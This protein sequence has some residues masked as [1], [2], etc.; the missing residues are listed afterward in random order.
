MWFFSPNFMETPLQVFP[1]RFS[2]DKKIKQMQ[3][4]HSALTV[5]HHEAPKTQTVCFNSFP[6]LGYETKDGLKSPQRYLGIIQRVLRTTEEASAAS[7]RSCLANELECNCFAT[8]RLFPLSQQ[9]LELNPKV[10][11]GCV[12]KMHCKR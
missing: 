8:Q 2:G 10:L 1:S 9:L 5:S 11:T 3:L 7:P 12:E 6:T 4:G